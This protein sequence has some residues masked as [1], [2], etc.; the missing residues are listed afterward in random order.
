VRELACADAG[1]IYRGR[2]RA[3]LA[4][5]EIALLPSSWRDFF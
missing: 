2:Y 3:T 4:H 1:R 5:Q